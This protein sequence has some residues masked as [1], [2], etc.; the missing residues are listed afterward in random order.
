MRIIDLRT[1]KL[2]YP[3]RFTM[4]HVPSWARVRQSDGT[5]PAPQFR[6]DQ[7]WYDNTTFPG[8]SGLSKNAKYCEIRNQSW[9]LGKKLSEVYTK[10]PCTR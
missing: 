8:E 9:P 7:E 5:F 2:R 6:T 10:A 1:A 4:E 3:Y